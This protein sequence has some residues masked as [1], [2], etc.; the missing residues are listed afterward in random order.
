MN[1]INTSEIKKNALDLGFSIIGI[2][3]AEH[4]EIEEK[5]LKKWIDNG[6]H[7]TMHWIPKRIEERGN[8]FNYFPEVKSV[9]SVGLNYFT[10]E[11]INQKENYKISNYSWGD[12]Y[13]DV[14]KR[15]LFLLLEYIQK[16]IPQVKYRV[17]VDTSPIMDKVWAQKAGLGWQGKHTNLINRDFGSWIFLGELL[18]DIEL[19]Y[20]QPFEKDLCGTC[21]ACIDDCPT[22]ALTEYVLDSN[23]CISYM[24]IEHRGDF[25]NDI[26]NNLD[27]WIYGCDVCQQVCPWNIKFEKETK[28]NS[29]YPREEIKNK[30]I[31]DWQNLTEDDFKIIFKKSPIKR[32]KYAG[33]KRNIESVTNN[34]E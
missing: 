5:K 31:E 25:E 6:N 29:F 34:N 15:K 3:K 2:A 13:H 26:G 19:D 12:D 8:I 14:L 30:N 16:S 10:N 18:L 17:C 22:D 20:D 21:T 4:L 28:E 7:A 11:D 1:L 33:L 32:T 24:T 27:G 9:I 23:K